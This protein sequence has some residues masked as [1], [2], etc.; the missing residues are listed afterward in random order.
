MVLKNKKIA[1]TGGAGLIGSFLAERLLT[2]GSKV[3]IVDD[4]SK[5]SLSNL[6]PIIKYLDIRK[7]DLENLSFARDSLND[8]EII[9]HLASRAYGVGYGNG[10]HLE[11]LMH[12][13]R[14]TNNIISVSKLI[15]PEHM[16]ITSSSCIY[17]DEGPDLIPEL[18]IF[19]GLPENVN[20]GYGWAKRFLEQKALI[21]AQESKIPIT[22]VRPFNIYGEHYR[23]VGEFSQAIPM[24][25]K[26]IL[27]KNSEIEVW[28]SGKQKRSYIHADDCA[29]AMIHLV[30]KRWTKSPVNIGTEIAISIQELV[31]LICSMSNLYPKIIYNI[32]KP[33]GR[34][35][36]S[37]DMSVFN[38]ALNDFEFNVGI[39][40][41]IGRMLNWYKNYNFDTNV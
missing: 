22:I 14:I 30:K 28:G 10:R 37:S 33:E 35:I 15:L 25:I 11:I 7:G 3:V 24:L 5:G 6:K 1:I 18:P 31:E 34:I 32:L 27:D 12:N 39:E 26:K 13:E 8:A 21:L 17:D 9:F 40:E 36:K 16:L 19:N 38:E 29:R 2:F 41:G 23:W 20:R 4:F